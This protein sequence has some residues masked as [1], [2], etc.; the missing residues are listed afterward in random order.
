MNVKLMNYKIF[1]LSGLMVFY[2]V[3][4]PGQVSVRIFA[5]QDPIS[6]VFNVTEGE[7]E[8]DHGAGGKLAVQKDT[9]VIISKYNGRLAVKLMNDDGFV[10][11]S[12]L[13]SGNTGRDLFSLRINGNFSARQYYSGDLKCFPDLGRLVLINNCSIDDYIGGVVRTEGGQGKNL[14][15]LKSQAVIA[16][17]Y[18]YKYFDKHIS[19]G[20]NLCDDTHCQA[21]NGVSSDTLV[22]QA[23]MQ[24]KGLVILGPD[25]TLIISAFHSNCGGETSPPENVWLSGQPYLKKVFDKYCISSP[26][27]RWRKTLSISDWTASLKN[28]GLTAV[29]A[30]LSLLN[31]SQITRQNDYRIGIFTVPLRQ[32]RSDLNLRSTFFSVKVE[33]TMVVLSGR[34][35]GHGVGLCQEGAM[36]MASKGFNFIQII[37]YYYQGVIVTDIKNA[38]K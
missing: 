38:V 1:Y 6:A 13:I 35:Y 15:Y 22:T 11:D 9:P 30:D 5:G 24:T 28:A 25:S 21:F 17:T 27:A 36:V 14:E 3:L 29:P 2:T 18:M 20:Y 23:T 10:C 34:G 8:I 19:D 7:Y 26:N 33:G 31:F 16:R 37:N 32:L 12:V 4:L